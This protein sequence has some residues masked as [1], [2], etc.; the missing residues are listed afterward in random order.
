MQVE[1]EHFRQGQGGPPASVRF[2]RLDAE[3]PY[4]YLVRGAAIREGRFDP[5]GMGDA[6]GR[7]DPLGQVRDQEGEG[8]KPFTD[9]A[10]VDDLRQICLRAYVRTPPFWCPE[11]TGNSENCQ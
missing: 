5:A 9:G 2:G 7:A 6:G 4:P 1:G 3:R 11:L 10:E 8:L